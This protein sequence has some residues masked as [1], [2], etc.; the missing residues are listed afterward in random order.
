MR[1]RRLRRVQRRRR[2]RVRVRRVRRRVRVRVRVRVRT[3]EHIYM[4]KLPRHVCW[5]PLLLRLLLLLPLLLRLLLGHLP[6]AL[7]CLPQE[8]L[9]L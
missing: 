8:L 4:I 3:C 5:H 1:L 2:V 6:L 9:L 7:G